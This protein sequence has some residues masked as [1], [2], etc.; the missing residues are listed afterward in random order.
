MQRDIKKSRVEHLQTFCFLFLLCCLAGLG[1]DGPS[2]RGVSGLQGSPHAGSLRL[3][4]LTGGPVTTA[5]LLYQGWCCRCHFHQLGGFSYV[6][7][8]F[9]LPSLARE[10][11]AEAQEL[12]TV[13]SQN[14]PPKSYPWMPCEDGKKI[15]QPYKG[16][17]NNCAL[18]V[19]YIF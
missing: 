15:H 18:E 8:Y 3:L 6:T 4:E 19:L 7:G 10:R 2:G 1:K 9:L 12:G 5:S 17:E 16:L 11:S 13:S 14:L